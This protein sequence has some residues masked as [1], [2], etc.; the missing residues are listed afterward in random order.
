MEYKESKNMKKTYQIL[1]LKVVMMNYE[2]VVTTSGPTLDTPV[3]D[4]YGDEF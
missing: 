4:F 1:G 3:E 2:D